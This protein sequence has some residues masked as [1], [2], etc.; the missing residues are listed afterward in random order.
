MRAL[1]FMTWNVRLF[2][3]TA[4]I[5]QGISY[6]AP[7]DAQQI[8]GA[9]SSLAVDDPPDVIAFNEVWSDEAADI[10][11]NEPNFLYPHSLK[12]FG[13]A[14]AGL[15]PKL[16]DSG[17]MVFSRFPFLVRPNGDHF[18]FRRYAESAGDDVLSDKGAALVQID[19]GGETTTIVFTHLQSSYDEDNSE[20]SNIRSQQLDDIS[21]LLHEILGDPVQPTVLVRTLTPQHM[22][23]CRTVRRLRGTNDRSVL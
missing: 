8:A 16:D 14:A 18:E 4:A 21:S 22:T 3:E 13:S 10:L 20:H 15:P 5:V 17:L 2:S 19:T 6:T 1:R 23:R 7:Y 12:T 11:R 9:I